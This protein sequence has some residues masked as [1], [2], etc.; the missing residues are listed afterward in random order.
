MFICPKMNVWRTHKNFR[1]LLQDSLQFLHPLF[2][3]HIVSHSAHKG[4]TV[5]RHIDFGD[6]RH[7]TFI[8]IFL[9]CAT[10]SLSIEFSWKAR[11]RSGRGELR[12]RFDLKTP[13][14]IFCQMPMEDID[15][16]LSQQINLSLQFL[17]IYERS[18]HIVHHSTHF[19]G[20]KIRQCQGFNLSIALCAQCQLVQCLCR[21][22]HSD[23]F[24]HCDGDSVRRNLQTI[25]FIAKS[26]QRIVKGIEGFVYHNFHFNLSLLRNCCSVI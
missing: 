16:K 10:F 6:N 3:L 26:S 4:L 7:T 22:H 15:L 20:R 14:L 13:R 12:K 5:T 18:S 2:G 17:D 19:E 9:Q 11:H 1:H 25:A 21:A 8:S 24:C 23:G